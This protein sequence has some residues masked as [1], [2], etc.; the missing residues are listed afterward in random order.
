MSKEPAQQNANLSG[1]VLQEQL[2]K[3]GYDSSS[4][5]TKINKI[6]FLLRKELLTPIAT[7]KTQVLPLTVADNS[8][9]PTTKQTI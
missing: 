5:E 3:W 1:I 2:T 9:I 6:N 4:I 8:T 7:Q